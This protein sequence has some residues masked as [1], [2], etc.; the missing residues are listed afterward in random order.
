MWGIG[1]PLA[2]HMNPEVHILNTSA[3]ELNVTFVG[4]CFQTLNYLA[5]L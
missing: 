5:L 4:V 2:Q 3:L 1:N